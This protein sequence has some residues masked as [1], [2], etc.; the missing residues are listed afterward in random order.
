MNSEVMSSIKLLGLKVS[1]QVTGFSG[2]V[3]SIGFDLYGCIQAIV[4]P[5]MK[6]PGKLEDSRW[7]DVKRLKVLHNVPVMAL[8]H[9]MNVQ[10]GFDKPIPR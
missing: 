1:D 6:D 5:E 10:G 7:F 2:V 8:P 3:T 4:S 9:F